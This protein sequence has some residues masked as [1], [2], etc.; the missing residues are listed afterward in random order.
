MTKESLK[1]FAVPR[2]TAD[3][4]PQDIAAWQR[5]EMVARAVL[6]LYGYREIRTPVF[7][8]TELFARSMGQTSDVVQKQMLTLQTQRQ[9]DADD[10]AK[11]SYSLRPEGT[12]SIVRSYIENNLDKKESFSKLF[13]LGP[14]FRG[15]R[16][17]KGRL[18]QFHQIG[19]E[20][21]GSNSSSPYLDAEVIALC[22]HL[23]S[24]LGLKEPTL[25]INTLGSPEDKQNFSNHLREQLKAR[26][27][28]LCGDCQSRFDRN[29]FRILDCKNRTC[30]AVVNKIDLS[31]SYL[32]NESRKYFDEVKVALKDLSIKFEYSPWL[33][34]GL[35]YYT[36][37]VFEITD[38][39]LGSQDALGAGGRYN[40]LVSQLG[41]PAVDAVGFALGIERILL[42]LPKD[43][44]VMTAPLDV[45][46]IPLDEPSFKRAFGYLESLRQVVYEF[47]I[48]NKIQKNFSIDMGFR[49]SSLK[50]QM[51]AANDRGARYVIILG[52]NEL[53]REKVTLK[54][55][56]TGVQEEKDLKDIGAITVKLVK[57]I[58]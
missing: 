5:V 47:K 17:Q 51:R 49:L 35:D 39:S 20:A 58:I 52:E 2:G 50:S 13:Y 1:K 40:N 36:H 8:E 38:A 29:V 45:Y 34:R 4:L 42:A 3:V 32:S 21:L 23:L 9:G 10:I 28:E 11:S 27:K 44:A 12:A 54:D 56:A 43:Q 6:E 15:E 33:V 46:I 57:G 24:A 25:K 26:L 22:M 18:R 19:V 55:M 53:K 14:M 37:T 7:E 30:Q 31:D 16:P 48:Q 41:G